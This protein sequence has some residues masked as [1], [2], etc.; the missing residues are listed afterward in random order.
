MGFTG[1]KD[2]VLLQVLEQCKNALNESHIGVGLVTIMLF[3]FANN[4]HSK[5]FIHLSL[6]SIN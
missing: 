4:A 1:P 2:C 6:N 5:L 3:R